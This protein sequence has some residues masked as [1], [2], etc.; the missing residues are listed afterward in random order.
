MS[1]PKG[2]SMSRCTEKT[3]LKLPKTDLH[4]HLDGSLRIDTILDVA[5][6]ERISLEAS[7]HRELKDTLIQDSECKDLVK[8]LEAF[9]VTVSV[10]QSENSLKRIAYE[11]IEDVSRENVRYLEVRFC[12]ILHTKKG[13]S[14]NG[15]V[16]SVLFGLRKAQK[17]F[18][19]KTG[20]I[21]CGL[22]HLSEDVTNRLA[23]LAVSYKGRG[24]VGFDMAGP[25]KDYPNIN[26]LNA[27]R[28]ILKNNINVTTHAGEAFGPASIHQAIHYCG[29]HR[30][31][32]G[33][34]LKDDP[35][36]MNYVNDHRIPLEV[37]ITSNVQTK[38]VK[39]LASHP[40]RFFFDA[41]LRVTINTDNRLIS[42]TTVT[43]ELSICVN[44]FDFS[45]PEL[46]RL[47]T[48]GFKSAFLGY[49]ERASM[50][51]KVNRELDGF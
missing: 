23:S 35:D 8:Y 47:I 18:K 50:L 44:E 51:E 15:V 36:L 24:V 29:A 30:I 46:K 7:S 9:N 17:K 19:V 20:L 33:A 14:L 41:G 13:L 34:T 25:E 11:L 2:N 3:I 12:P 48:N 28:K 45:K 27:F 32:H 39:N 6:E 4:C 1:F 21:I 49:R 40:I 38:A 42:N 16:E 26:Y 31:G 5:K 37:C 22:K 43:K 10:M